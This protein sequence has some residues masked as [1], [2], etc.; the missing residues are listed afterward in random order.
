[1]K[2]SIMIML[3]LAGSLFAADYSGI[4]NGK[5]GIVS[6]K[7]GSVPQTAQLTLLQ[8]GSSLQGTFKLNNQKPVPIGSGTVNG[9]SVTFAIG[10]GSSQ[11]TA[12]LAQSGVQLVG[13]M[14]T[15]T[16][17]VFNLAFTKH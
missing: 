16:G 15:P 14:T 10:A 1:M 5:G 17:E 6:A 2:K 8:D 4:W 12:H 3:A 7:Y 13:T 9:T 11:L